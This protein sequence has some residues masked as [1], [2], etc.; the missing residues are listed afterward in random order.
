MASSHCGTRF[1]C[2]LSD[3]PK[4]NDIIFE[5]NVKVLTS[6]ITDSDNSYVRGY[7]TMNNHYFKRNGVMDSIKR[8]ITNHIVMSYKNFD[9]KKIILW[10]GGAIGILLTGIITVAIGLLKK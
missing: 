7:I 6:V 4:A 1:A 2:E 5:D 3:S 9:D 8:S 10:T